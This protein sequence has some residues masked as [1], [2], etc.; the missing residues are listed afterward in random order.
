MDKSNQPLYMKDHNSGEVYQLLNVLK[1]DGEG[2]LESYS[3]NINIEEEEEE[4]EEEV[5]YQDFLTSRYGS[6]SL[7]QFKILEQFVEIYG[8]SSIFETQEDLMVPQYVETD[9]Q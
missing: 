7:R 1:E 6:Y 3:S 2:I 8:D 5:N 9:Y 4:K